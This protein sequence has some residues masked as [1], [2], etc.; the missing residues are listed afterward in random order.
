MGSMGQAPIASAAAH[1][2][3]QGTTTGGA[4]KGQ[5]LAL[6]RGQDQR[7]MDP[8]E[9]PG[10]GLGPGHS[11]RVLTS[12]ASHEVANRYFTSFKL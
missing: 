1:P 4:S 6:P 12:A 8:M 9:V 5:D 10:V 3:G 2:V 7:L 11:D